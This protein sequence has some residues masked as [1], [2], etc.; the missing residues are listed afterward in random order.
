MSL[1]PPTPVDLMVTHG[2]VITLDAQRRIFS[3]GA[4]AI[5]GSRIV[6]VG[7]SA[8]LERTY[9][10]QRLIDAQGGVL[11]PGFVDCHVH[12]SQH[13]GRGTIPD[14]WPEEREHDQWLPYWTHMT[15]DDAYRSAMLACL[16]M[17]RN[18]TTT[19]CD[20]GARFSGELNAAVAEKVGL[21]GI[22]SEVCWDIPPHPE[23]AVGDA[24]ACLARLERLVKALPAAPESR[25]WAG[26]GMAG[27]GLCSDGLL[28]EG[29]KLA[30]RYG[31]VMDMHQSFGPVDVARYKERTGGKPAVEHFADLGILGSNL[32]LV[33]MI[34][35]EASEVSLLASTGTNIVHCPAAST[36]VG[37]GVSRVGRF[38]EMVARGVNVA[39][40]SDSGNYSDFFDV[41]RQAY[42]AATLHREARGKMPTISAE[43][44]IEMATINGARSLGMVDQIGSLEPGKKA[45]IVVH[46][47]RRPEWRPGLDVMNSLVYSAQS[48]GVD[49][50]IVDGEIILCE[51]QFTQ[52]DEQAEYRQIDRAARALYQRMGFQVQNRWPVI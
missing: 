9:A 46:A 10:A 49:T 36:R 34:Y 4:V 19:F 44:V 12:L 32:Q 48:T 1:H 52:I 2:V 7:R 26:V 5:D 38:P 18:G 21:R 27:M 23:V 50:V 47:Y 31:V 28:V 17:V 35:T 40:G 33:H 24:D 22:V 37:M 11:Q 41:G 30:D 43:Q 29:K 3:D 14:L 39:L 13:L 8:D 25:V 6:D 45:D 42:L 20:N 15:E 16:E 51:G